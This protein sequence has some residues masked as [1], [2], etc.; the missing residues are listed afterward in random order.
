MTRP[1]SPI[2]PAEPPRR[3]LRGFESAANLTAAHVRRAGEGRGIAV[4]RIL[5]DWAAVVGAETAAICRPLRM[6]HGKGGF[7]ATLVLLA[8]GAQAPRLAMALPR[9]RDQVNAVYGFN[10]VARI[11]I[12][13]TAPSG[14]A[15]AQAAF[16]APAALAA[17]AVVP[18]PALLARAEAAAAGVD[19]PGLAEALRRFALHFHSRRDA[20]GGRQP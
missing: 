3:R 15:E 12:T 7:G 5:T 11:T 8:P 20:T 4:G 10:A 2:P 19:D 13:Q 18:S 14:F 6:S 16:A 17:A 9:I 1:R